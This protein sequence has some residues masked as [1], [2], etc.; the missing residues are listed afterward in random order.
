MT[1][2]SNLFKRLSFVDDLFISST[3]PKTFVVFEGP[4]FFG[5]RIFHLRALEIFCTP[6]EKVAFERKCEFSRSF[7]VGSRGGFVEFDQW[8]RTKFRFFGRYV[9]FGGRFFG[10]WFAAHRK[11][12]CYGRRA[13]Q[14]VVKSTSTVGTSG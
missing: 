2:A 9:R 1:D 4:R 14:G 7:F 11:V 13:F 12:V 10:K 8:G 3:S 6:I 5:F